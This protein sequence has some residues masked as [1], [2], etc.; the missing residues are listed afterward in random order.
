[1]NAPSS[2]RDPSVS[3]AIAASSDPGAGT[4][5]QALE[6]SPMRSYSLRVMKGVKREGRMDGRTVTFMDASEINR[7]SIEARDD[8]HA[9][10]VAEAWARSHHFDVR[11][12]NHLPGVRE[13]SIFVLDRQ[14]DAISPV[15]ASRRQPR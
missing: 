11:T 7:V 8:D 4:E 2:P 6:Q 3:T 9:R 13:M 14:S 5:I 15:F 12:V 1:M 10:R